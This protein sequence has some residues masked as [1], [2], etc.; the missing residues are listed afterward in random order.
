MKKLIAALLVTLAACTTTPTTDTTVSRDPVP[1]SPP[2]SC[3]QAC[4][5]AL[6]VCGTAADD[7]D[8]IE[9]CATPCSFSAAE[10]S[11]LAALSCGDDTSVCY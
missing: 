4:R 9:S 11:C 1:A 5:V 7:R 3:A 10:A 8:L 6:E 2:A